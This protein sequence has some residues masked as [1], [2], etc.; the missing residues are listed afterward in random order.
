MSEA[1]GITKVDVGGVSVQPSY[2]YPRERD[3]DKRFTYHPPKPGQLGR[4]VA[5]RDQAKALAELICGQVPPSRE[6]SLAL[7][8]LEESVMW[9]N[10]GIARNE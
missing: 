4:Y 10:A 9:A 5:M 1:G 2:P 8:A 6:R 7:T 3:L